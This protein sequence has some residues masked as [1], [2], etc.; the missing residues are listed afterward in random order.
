[1]GEHICLNLK[2]DVDVCCVC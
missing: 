2:H 1:M